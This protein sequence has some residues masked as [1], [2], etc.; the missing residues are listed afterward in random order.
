VTERRTLDE[1]DPPAWGEPES[2]DTGLVVRCH[3]LRRKPLDEFTAADL[4]VMIGQQ[5]AL[6]HL[7]PLALRILDG[8][9]LIE[10]EYYPGDLMR[11]VLVI[12]PA[13]WEGHQAEWLRLWN[14][15]D[16]LL[17]AVDELGEP[18]DRL[19]SLTQP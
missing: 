10:A 18:I 14:I 4:R 11:N 15:V 19:R 7:V 5:I 1:L 6:G 12:D 16:G 9:P 17:S 13:Y 3:E 2:G 8:H